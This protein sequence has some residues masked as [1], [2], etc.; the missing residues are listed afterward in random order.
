MSPLE[1]FWSLCQQAEMAMRSPNS[2]GTPDLERFGLE[3]L[4]LIEGHSDIRTDFEAAF[5]E[6]WQRTP[7]T[8][9]EIVMFC[10]HTL[11]WL[12]VRRFYEQQLQSAVARQDW[13][14]EPVA[15]RILDSFN[16][17]WEDRDL[18]PYYDKPAKS[19]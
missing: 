17:E 7:D 14:A 8:P 13:R 19:A 15:R 3:I 10:M 11:R 6:L 4:N 2:R 5:C 16:D 9:W 12:N 18:F 1:Q